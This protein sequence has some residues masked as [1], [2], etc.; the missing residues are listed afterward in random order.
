MALCAE[1][2]GGTTQQLCNSR[3]VILAKQCVNVPEDDQRWSKQEFLSRISF[4]A[5]GY[6]EASLV[7]SWWAAQLWL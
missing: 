6:D 7:R 4:H 3:L 1:V 2:A 5:G